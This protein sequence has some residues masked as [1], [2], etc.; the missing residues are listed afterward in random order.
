[1]IHVTSSKRI[2]I[3]QTFR[4]A[5]WLEWQAQGNW[6]K[7]WL[8]LLYIVARPLTAALVLVFNLVADV[9]Y[10]VLDPRIKYS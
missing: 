10:G 4:T 9:V 3:W 8:F 6:T 5:A 2:S 7:P 1:M